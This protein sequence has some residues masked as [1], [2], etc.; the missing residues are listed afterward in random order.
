[1]TQMMLDMHAAFAA[2]AVRAPLAIAQ[3]FAG[4]AIVVG[5]AAVL[6]A[7]ALHAVAPAAGG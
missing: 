5:G 6:A 3:R 4:I 2:P 7:Q 1:M